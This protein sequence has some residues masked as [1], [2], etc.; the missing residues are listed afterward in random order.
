[1]MDGRTHSSED[2]PAKRV[3]FC[4]GHVGLA[5]ERLGFRPRGRL[6]FPKPSCE[7]WLITGASASWQFRWKVPG[8]AQVALVLLKEIEVGELSMPD[9]SI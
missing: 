3:A 8:S 2:P 7:R 9:E 5:V 1:M 6:C 4:F